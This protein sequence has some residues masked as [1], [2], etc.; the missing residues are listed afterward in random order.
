MAVKRASKSLRALSKSA[1]LIP[2]YSS[3]ASADAPPAFTELG[4]RFTKY[5]EAKIDSEKVIYGSADRYDIDVTQ[6]NLIT[7]IG[8]NW[9]FTLDVQHDAMSGASPWFVGT[10]AYSQPGVIMSGASI[11]DNRTEVAATTRYYFDNGNSGIKLSRSEEDDY[12]SKSITLDSSFNSSDN[13]R[14]YSVALSR[15]NDE[16]KPTQGKVP[17]GFKFGR[18]NTESV[19]LAISQIINRTII[20]KFGLSY[21]QR[22]GQLSDPYKLLDMRPNARNSST[23]NVSYRQ[24]FNSKNASLRL[25]YR[26]YSDTWD[27]R[28]QT[29]TAEWYQNFKF[30]AVVPYLRYYSQTEAQFFNTI[31]ETE[32]AYFSDDYRLSSFGAITTGIRTE[33]DFKKWKFELQA[34]RYKTD[35]AW[36]ISKGK[37]SP[38]IVDFWRLSL[39]MRYRF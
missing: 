3:Y 39:G 38:A 5:K 15:S 36:S 14:T 24:Y 25:D 10:D 13:L 9:S 28:A 7:P 4:L 1:A 34:E 31:A 26:Y 11:S 6:A 27:I 18:K 22:R 29:L 37:D 16:I 30:A 17:T 35:P 20:T 33:Y 2:L 32:Q 19:W 8:R 12:A 23:V 21:T